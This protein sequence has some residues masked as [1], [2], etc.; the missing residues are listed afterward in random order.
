MRIGSTAY[1][2]YPV[3]V[4]AYGDGG[5]AGTINRLCIP[6]NACPA[7]CCYRWL[8]VVMRFPE[9]GGVVL[10]NGEPVLL[11]VEITCGQITPE[12]Y[13]FVPLPFIF[14]KLKSGRRLRN[15]PYNACYAQGYSY[16][17]I[18]NQDSCFQSVIIGKVA[19]IRITFLP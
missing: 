3:G 7:V 10:Y 17:T 12:L 6:G 8:M 18:L 1:E 5:V 9:V 15:Q 11:Q 14:Y 4:G 16:Q 2:L 13:L 19:M